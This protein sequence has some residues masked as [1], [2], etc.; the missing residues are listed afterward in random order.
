M[1]ISGK[2]DSILDVSSDFKLNGPRELA[3]H[4]T[5]LIGLFPFHGFDPEII[6]LCTL[7]P[8]VKDSQE[9]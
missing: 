9:Q 5:I 6:L 4:I 7:L 8:I 2:N 1:M 3:S